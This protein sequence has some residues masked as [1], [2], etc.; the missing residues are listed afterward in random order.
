MSLW[1]LTQ[2]KPILLTYNAARHCLTVLHLRSEEWHVPSLP[3]HCTTDFPFYLFNLIG[4]EIM[5]GAWVSQRVVIWALLICLL[6]THLG[7]ASPLCSQRSVNTS[8]TSATLSLQKEVSNQF[9]MGESEVD[10][11]LVETSLRTGK[12]NACPTFQIFSL[13]CDSSLGFT[14]KDSEHGVKHH[15]LSR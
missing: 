9:Q 2:T 10:F 12:M 11:E 5:G 14:P 8:D 13:V 4:R 15:Q 6:P 7:T 3:C 1:S